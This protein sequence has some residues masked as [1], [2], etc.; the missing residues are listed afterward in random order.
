MAWRKCRRRSRHT[1]SQLTFKASGR[2]SVE[3]QKA[4][5][6]Q[7]AQLA[8]EGKRIIDQARGGR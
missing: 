8:A 4:F 7:R 1:E 6:E 5:D 2:E 3:R